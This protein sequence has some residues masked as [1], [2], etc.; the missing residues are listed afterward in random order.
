MKFFLI[1]LLLIGSLFSGTYDDTYSGLDKK[2]VKSSEKLDPFMNGKFLE[3]IRFDRLDFSDGEISGT[4]ENY[5]NEMSKIILRYVEDKKDIQIK[6]IGHSSKDS[7]DVNEALEVS[8]NF[9]LDIA[10]KL[11]EKDI[12]QIGRAHV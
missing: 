8:K 11:E 9:A 6:I 2:D 3:I 10:K 4:S 12:N 1:N 7:G 5:L